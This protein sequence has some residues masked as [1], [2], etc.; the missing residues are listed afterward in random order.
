MLEV[1]G[2]PVLRHVLE[3]YARQGGRRFVLAA[4][5]LGHVIES[6]AKTL[7]SEWTVLVVDT[8]DDAD[9]GQRLARCLDFVDGTFLATY[10]DGLGDVALPALVE[11]HR[12]HEAGATVTVVPLPSQYGTLVVGANGRVT[13]FREKPILADHLINAGFFV[14]EPDAVKRAGG[15]SLE[16]DVLPRLAA[17]GELVAY[18]H[19]GFWRSLDTYKDVVELERLSADHGGAP[20]MPAHLAR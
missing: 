6:Y 13:E 17:S 18:P 2:V 5:Y 15:S 4:G 19:R 11:H 16:R 9:T 8:G 10:G 3:I 14:F 20:W 7:P 12:S 1:A